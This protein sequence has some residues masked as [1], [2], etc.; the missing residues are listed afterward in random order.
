MTRF[1]NRK[2]LNN[3]QS[4]RDFIR[5]GLSLALLILG[6]GGLVWL[7]SAPQNIS[8]A[9]PTLKAAIV[10]QLSSS[11]PRPEMIAEATHQFESL[12]FQVD[13]YGGNDVSVD[14]FRNLPER[15]YRLILFRSHSGVILNQSGEPGS[16]Y[17][18]YLFTNEPYNALKYTLE[19]LNND[20][21]HAVIDQGKPDFFAV[22]PRFI[23]SRMNG[24]LDKTVVIIDGCH[25]L[26]YEDLAQAFI[27]KGA[28][29]YL[30]WNASVNLN[31]VDR[32]TMSLIKN[33]CSNGVNISRSVELTNKENGTDPDTG[34]YLKYYP[35]GC[36]VKSL[37]ELTIIS[38]N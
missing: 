16:T 6:I 38:P 12:G 22:G 33:L 37:K 10:D 25:G 13:Y 30:A 23:T 34:A 27:A 26:Y 19:R 31:Y 1:R 18:T 11:Y 8:S 3:W 24:N 9:P 5:L 36:G 4:K 32:A 14:L 15:H 28:S 35:S 7:I 2:Q 29:A 21:V 20:I 17:G